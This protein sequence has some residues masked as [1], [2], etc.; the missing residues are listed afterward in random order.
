M[1]HFL[2]TRRKILLITACALVLIA[3]GV[4]LH[5]Y[6]RF[7][8]LVNERLSGQVF[9][10]TSLVLSAPLP[11]VPG[12]EISPQSVEDWLRKAF[13]TTGTGQGAAVGEFHLDGNSL[14]VHPGRESFF[15]DGP[16][17][18][19]PA[20]IQFSGG[21]ISSITD[22]AHGAPLKQ[23]L[24]EPAVI[25]TLFDRNRS[26]RLIITY[27]DCP[28]VLVDAVLAAEDRRFFSHPGVNILRL[29]KAALTDIRAD[30][31]LQGGSTLT[32]QLARNFF[33]TPRR[34]FKRKL[35]EIFLAMLIEQRVSKQAIFGMYANEVY[36]GQ[37]GSF[38]IYGFG[39]AADSY[40][41]KD[42]KDL[43]LPEAALLAGMIRGPNL[44]SPYRYPARARARRNEVLR[45]MTENH[46]ISVAQAQQASATP[47]GVI[48]KNMG[49]TQAP[50]FVDMVKDDLLAH[51]PERDLAN[52]SYR[53]YTTLD[54]QL[55]AAAVNAVRKG[56]K[57]VDERI[58]QRRRNGAPPP[59]PHEP[60]TALVVLDPHTGEIRA[61]VG[62]RSYA[63]SQLNHA[64]AMRQ[65]GSCF[66]PF[67][68][69]AALNSGI[70]GARPLITPA[71]ILPDQ[72]MA[73]Q[74]GN[75]LYTP[76]DFKDQ[77][78]GQVT[79]R[80]ALALSLNVAT[81]NLAQMIG[82]DKIRN[83]ALQVGLN[84]GIQA[85]P[86]IALGSYVATPVQM[87]GAY[88]VF[89]NGGVYEQ[90]RAVL[91]VKNASGQTV[92]QD[93]VV[94][95]NVLDPR[96][97]YLMVNLMETVVDHGTGEAVRARG[98][99]APAAGKT[100]TLHD[101]WFA[102][103]TSNLLAVTWVGYDN[104]HDLNLTGASSALPIWTDFMKAAVLLP[105]Y[106]NTEPFVPPL[107]LISAP[108]GEQ[109]VLAT[110]N[111]PLP[112]SQDIFI[113]GTQPVSTS[114]ASTVTSWIRRI[115]P[116]GKKNPP[117]AGQVSAAAQPTPLSA[118]RRPPSQSPANNPSLAGSPQSPAQTAA[119]AKKKSGG[120]L[121]KLFSIFKHHKNRDSGSPDQ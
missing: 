46:F 44:Y 45:L 71:T 76:H 2:R 49:G 72:P 33:L 97:A 87:A 113:D 101:G 19:G 108:V 64:L 25:T 52:Q 90:P 40:F 80:E 55:E 11:V 61:L 12:E 34:T 30:R 8:R 20:T 18:E 119:P 70:D 81:V 50:Y 53:I 62:G 15:A 23:Y 79:V 7:S 48:Q 21:Q 4:F 35:E 92:W 14:S 85:T 68:Y 16:D 17:Q 47:L 63:A 86:A 65:P 59:K 84:N 3:S 5:Y 110:T 42:V 106:K 67:V 98:F 77:Y 118:T 69:A 54:P 75:V 13:Y 36:M 27:S 121:K 10:R 28:K 96:V 105:G 1:S 82:Y 111:N 100:G 83:L 6:I 104:N 9:H 39:E 117:Q 22:L 94:S 32:M 91:A 41:N 88:S 120:V 93:P 95:R 112:A 31:R 115:L 73:F 57:E 29:V 37:R 24:L 78:Y 116:F 102:G 26:K 51:L 99:T 74:F 60:Q 107:G 89:A 114:A 43:T 58:R 103:F 56:I 109:A 38:S 66:K